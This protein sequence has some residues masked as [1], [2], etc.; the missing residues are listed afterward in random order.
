MIN[1]ILSIL[2][3]TVI[4]ILFK[5]IERQKISIFPPIVIN[6]IAASILGFSINST[7][8]PISFQTISPWFIFSVVIG[9]LLI[10]NF[11]FIGSSTQKAGIAITTVSA[12]MSFVLPVLFSL[13][14]DVN[15]NFSL[16]K[17]TLVLLALVSVLLVILPSKYNINKH[18]SIIYPVLLFIGLGLLDSLIKYCQYYFI[19]TP[20]SSSLFSA[21]NFSIAGII[22]LI[23]LLF[24]KKNKL[25]LKQPKVLIIGIM[26]GVANFGSMYFLINALNTLKFNSSLVFGINNI[27]TVLLSVFIAFIFYKERFSKINWIGLI[28]SLFILLGMIR[29]FI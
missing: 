25:A 23:L 7:N 21:V 6:Y 17:V 12:K 16:T 29:I 1:L 22:G 26:L 2:S 11:Y 20:Q 13:L 14:F 8:A 28:L 18:G 19:T 9:I 27:G 24:S 15:D 3:S 4:L 10:I 5:I